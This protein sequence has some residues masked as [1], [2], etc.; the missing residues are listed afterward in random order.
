MHLSWNQQDGIAKALL[1]AYPEQDR[2]ALGHEDLRRL[3]V[4]LPGFQD[5][6][7]PPGEAWLSKILW[8]WMRLAHES[9]DAAFA[10]E[11]GAVEVASSPCSA[12]RILPVTGTDDGRSG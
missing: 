12:P 9:S 7:Y 5:N 2:L 1:R 4:A 6:P 11:E 3:I 10:A 8:T